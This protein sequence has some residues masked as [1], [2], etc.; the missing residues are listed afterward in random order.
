MVRTTHCGSETSE[1]YRPNWKK[2]VALNVML[3]TDMLL[4][5]LKKKKNADPQGRE[6]IPSEKQFSGQVMVRPV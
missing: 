5:G 6:K 2:R 4:S 3:L 1:S